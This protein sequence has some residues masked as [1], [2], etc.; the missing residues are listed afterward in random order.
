M[1]QAKGQTN[2]KSDHGKTT[3]SKTSTLSSWKKAGWDNGILGS[4]YI[5]KVE[6]V[7]IGK[8]LVISLHDKN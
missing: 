7:R 6:T 5:E 4:F 1:L 2:N 3:M 8:S